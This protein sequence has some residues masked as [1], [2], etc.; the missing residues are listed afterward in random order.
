MHN[1]YYLVIFW[2]SCLETCVICTSV[3]FPSSNRKHF[4]FIHETSCGMQ[5]SYIF[6]M[7][8]DP[9]SGGC[10]YSLL[11]DTQSTGF[12]RTVLDHTV[13]LLLLKVIHHTACLTYF[14]FLRSTDHCLSLL[15]EINMR[16]IYYLNSE[17]ILPTCWRDL[18]LVTK[19]IITLQKLWGIFL[20]FH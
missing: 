11:V 13:K 10:T 19:S 7:T 16:N 18:K 5:V 3:T 8:V 1:P 9:R 6:M 14:I 12:Y 17:L 4:K 2:M 15:N 20:F